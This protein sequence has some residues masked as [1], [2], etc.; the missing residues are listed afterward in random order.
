MS[1]DETTEKMIQDKNL[2]APRLTPDSIDAVIERAIF[3]RINGTTLTYCTL[4]LKNG[5]TVTGES[6][7]VSLE[8]F[9]QEIGEKVAR[10]NAREKIWALE[11]YLL[12]QRLYEQGRN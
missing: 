4:M 9:D 8:N 12:K 11:G 2:N 1:N 5:F 3:T 10:E 6:A 7:A